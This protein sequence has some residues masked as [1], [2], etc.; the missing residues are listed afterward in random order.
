VLAI[1]YCRQ[2]ERTRRFTTRRASVSVG[3]AAGNDLVLADP[4]VSDRHCRLSERDGAWFVDD[5]GSE[6][7]TRVNGQPITEP[8]ALGDR[9]RI[10]I[11]AFVLELEDIDE[12]IGP[13]EEG[14]LDGI[15]RGDDDARAIYADWLEERGEVVCAEFLRVQQSI[16]D[17]PID[18]P[19]QKAEFLARSQRLRELAASI[20]VEWRM[21]VARPAVEGCRVAFEIPCKMDWGLLE[22]TDRPE[23]RTCNTC[24]KEVHYCIAEHEARDLAARGQCVVV[25]VRH[26]AAPCARCGYDV[27]RSVPVCMACGAA[28]PV[29]HPSPYALDSLSLTMGRMVIPRDELFYE[30]DD[31]SIQ[32]CG[33]C[34]ALNPMAFRFCAT[35][36]ERLARSPRAG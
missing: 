32:L 22:P 9:D 15:A 33:S 23:V 35:C 34:Y 2:D 6:R 28:R 14:L 31:D 4:T 29:R 27:P 13:V 21:R 25:D 30:D 8:V 1:H 7:G 24:H 17:D 16:I 26:V 36:G 3:R 18:T 5:L 11:G 12:R 19:A 20:D 10:Y